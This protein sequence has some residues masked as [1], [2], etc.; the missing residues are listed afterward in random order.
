MVINIKMSLGGDLVHFRY[1]ELREYN[2]FKQKD[3]ANILGIE[4]ITYAHWELLTSDMPLDICNTLANL[5]HVSVDYL[6]GISNDRQYPNSLNKINYDIMC[7]RLK[8]L[9]KKHKLL[10]REVAIKVGF[11]VATYSSYERGYSI[12]T[13]LKLFDI[14]D[15]YHC[16]MDYLIGRIDDSMTPAMPEV[17]DDKEE[18]KAKVNDRE[19]KL[20][21]LRKEKKLYQKD[22]A[23]IIG[24]TAVAYAK[25]ENLNNDIPIDICNKL[26]N[27]YN[28]SLDYLFGLTNTPQYDNTS[29]EISTE[30]L[31]QRL[32][33]LRKERNL[34]QETVGEM[35]SMAQ[36][37]YSDYENGKK[38][39]SILKLLD[40]ISIYNVSLDY[41]LGKIDY[42]PH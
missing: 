18:I 39:P 3:I 28:V 32:K 30:I 24:A 20:K 23:K 37:A 25:W 33:E 19:I 29:L 21:Y 41:V 16:S 5:Y 22:I 6:L 36:S 15:F 11:P 31:C 4:R 34:K 7:Q 17:S 26:A 38:I 9:R 13:T 14:A 12:P 1:K 42:N 35:L 2:K 10:Q 8:E 40:L 27:Y